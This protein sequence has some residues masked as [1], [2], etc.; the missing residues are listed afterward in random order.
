VPLEFKKNIEIKNI[1]VFYNNPNKTVLNNISLKISKGDCVGIIGKSGAGKSTLLDTLMGLIKPNAGNIL[2]DGKSIYKNLRSWQKLIGYVPQ[3]I[4]LIDDS[5]E[6]NI[7]FGEN[8]QDINI[9]NLINCAKDAEI[10]DLINNLPK[11]EKSL[12]GEKGSKLSG[13]EKQRIAIA[14]SLYISPEIII[15]DEATSSLDAQTEKKIV[16]SIK[17]LSKNKTVIIVSHKISSL[18]ICNKIYEMK[19]GKIYLNK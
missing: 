3:S 14:R 1:K 12:V 17:K 2:V 15:F 5:I 7:A 13:G 8:E 16:D 11:K 6:K 18:N 9:R 19:N 10:F 4:Y